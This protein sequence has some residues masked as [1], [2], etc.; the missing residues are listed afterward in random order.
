MGVVP[1]TAGVIGGIP[2]MGF[3]IA[4]IIDGVRGGSNKNKIPGGPL[5]ATDI[6]FGG[7]GSV[8][9]MGDIFSGGLPKNAASG[10]IMGYGLYNSNYGQMLFNSSHSNTSSGNSFGPY[11]VPADNTRV[12]TPKRI[13]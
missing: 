13:K 7:D 12:V 8:G 4:K 2:T 11:I 9:Q 6:G 10:F 1:G 3:G 5:E